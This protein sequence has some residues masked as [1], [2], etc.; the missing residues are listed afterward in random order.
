[1]RIPA[2]T[3]LALSL[4]L[5]FACQGAQAQAAS[6]PGEVM[7]TAAP[8]EPDA[9]CLST[10]VY[11]KK[12]WIY[13]SSNMGN[14]LYD[15]D[16]YYVALNNLITKAKDNGYNG[17]ALSSSYL[18]LLGTPDNPHRYFVDN[19]KALAQKAK[20]LGIDLI[21]VSGGPEIPKY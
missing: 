18:T 5:V 15:Q 11:F 1:M 16:P 14:G 20:D 17:I 3:P 21:P 10:N 19:F 13:Y 8:F 4:G 9:S 7:T 6:A 12:R 2:L